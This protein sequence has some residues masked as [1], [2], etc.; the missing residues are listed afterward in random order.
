MT[1]GEG[2]GLVEGL[3]S[4]QSGLRTL[5]KFDGSSPRWKD[6]EELL[7]VVILSTLGLGPCCGMEFDE[8]DEGE[9]EVVLNLRD[10]DSVPPPFPPSETSTRKV[11]LLPVPFEPV[12]DDPFRCFVFL[13]R[14]TRSGLLALP[15]DLYID[16]RLI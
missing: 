4:T 14:V 16:R 8:V 1:E 10:D 3:G 5:R 12:L 7:V 13:S 9:A 2:A 6:D 11:S 15:G